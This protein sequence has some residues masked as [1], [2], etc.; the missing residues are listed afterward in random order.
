MSECAGGERDEEV[1]FVGTSHSTHYS[2]NLEGNL[3]LMQS[4]ER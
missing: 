3:P 1:E 2:P 4:V